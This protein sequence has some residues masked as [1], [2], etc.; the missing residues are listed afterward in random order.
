MDARRYVIHPPSLRARRRL[1]A[2]HGRRRFASTC[3]CTKENAKIEKVA[4]LSVHRCAIH[5]M[6]V[7]VRS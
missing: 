3:P 6:S 1:G 2:R 7:V 5:A 4:M